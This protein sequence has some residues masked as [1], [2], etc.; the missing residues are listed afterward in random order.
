MRHRVPEE[1]ELKVTLNPRLT[2]GTSCSS[3]IFTHAFIFFFN[4]L[5]ST[6]KI[7][8]N[9][10][11]PPISIQFPILL[12]DA[13]FHFSP[14]QSCEVE[15]RSGWPIREHFIL[16]QTTPL[17]PHH[18]NGHSEKQFPLR[19][20]TINHGVKP[21]S[22]PRHCSHTNTHTLYTFCLTSVELKAHLEH[23][24]QIAGVRQTHISVWESAL[25]IYFQRNAALPHLTRRQKWI[26]KPFVLSI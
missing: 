16:S 18:K 24:V 19:P 26:E 23:I 17:T 20:M 9:Y 5:K 11:P 4:I 14:F 13:L 25:T 7:S 22:H 8:W 15:P 10:I 3:F 6:G 21:V 12:L 1:D 2:E